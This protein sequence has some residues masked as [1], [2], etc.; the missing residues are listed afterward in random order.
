M[1]FSQ[2]SPLQ[3]YSRQK[4]LER[5]INLRPHLPVKAGR[6]SGAENRKKAYQKI[7]WILR[8]STTPR[9]VITL[10]IT[11]KRWERLNKTGHEL[12]CTSDAESESEMLYRP[13]RIKGELTYWT[14]RPNL[15]SPPQ[16][17]GCWQQCMRLEDY[18][19]R[20][21]P[22]AMVKSWWCPQLGVSNNGLV[23]SRLACGK[24]HCCPHPCENQSFY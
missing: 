2:P 9:Q 21:L 22:S 20:R 4:T 8:S 1:G 18:G 14:E 23:P 24:T 5:L 7:N 19:L 11:W 3:K 17:P 16:L 12:W 6:Q 13:R 15:S 10:P